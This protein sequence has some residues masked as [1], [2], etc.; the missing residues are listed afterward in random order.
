MS[1]SCGTLYL[2]ATPIGNLGDIT[3]RVLATLADVDLIAA[4]DTRNTLRLL[5]HFDI[6]T[7]LTSYHEYNKVTKAQDLIG[8]LQA[9]KSI[10]L[11]TDA[12]T[13]AISDPGEILVDRCHEAGIPVTSLPGPSAVITALSLA[14]L[15]TRRFVF[16]GFLP[17][18]EDKKM[19]RTVLLALAKEP[20]TIVLYEAP[21][22]LRMLLADLAEALGADRR[23]AL[24]RELTKKFEEVTRITIGEA[25]AACDEKEPRGEY[26]LVIEGEGFEA[27][28]ARERAAWEEMSVA[29]HVAFYEAQGMP[30]KDAMKAA[31]RDRGI[32]KNEVYKAL[33]I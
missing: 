12:G 25:L 11:V 13:P 6:H 20:R 33:L 28:K 16:E 27:A 1:E 2:C 5:T 14:G 4:E 3:A 18:R 21:H 8:L 24:C 26:V 19:R 22:H 23:L 10:A 15:P 7:E 32:S 9:G 31:A 17:G 30:R 29:E